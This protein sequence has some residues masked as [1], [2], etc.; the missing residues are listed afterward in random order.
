MHSSRQTTASFRD[1]GFL[2]LYHADHVGKCS[3]SLTPLG[4]S[5]FVWA[6]SIMQQ[7]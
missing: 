7:A 1:A 6:A 4:V 3:R 2:Y 5:G